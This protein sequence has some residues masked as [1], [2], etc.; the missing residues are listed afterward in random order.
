MEGHSENEENKDVY[1]V[2]RLKQEK[3]KNI[4]IC[5]GANLVQQLINRD[6]I[7][8]YYITLIPTLLGNGIR[9]FDNG[10]NE[11]KL[12]LIGTQNYNGMVDLIYDRRDE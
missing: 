5:G 2:E 10:E 11:I 7:D 12:R 9:L 6:L 3:G 1:L 4:W 8:Y